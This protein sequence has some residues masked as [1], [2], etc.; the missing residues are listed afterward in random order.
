ML[1]ENLADETLRDLCNADQYRL[2]ATGRSETVLLSVALNLLRNGFCICFR[3][4]NKFGNDFAV[5]V[6]PPVLSFSFPKFVSCSSLH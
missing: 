2:E 5:C 1:F 3:G 6:R 4:A